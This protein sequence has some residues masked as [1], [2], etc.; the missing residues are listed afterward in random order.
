MLELQQMQEPT[1][2]A[3]W[4]GPEGR[5]LLKKRLTFRF[6]MCTENEFPLRRLH[7]SD[8]LPFINTAPSANCASHPHSALC[9]RV[10]ETDNHNLILSV[11]N[12]QSDYS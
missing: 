10:S 2:V 8:A 12:I 1:F 11:S 4:Q 9:T 3:Q 7:T 5:N 6:R